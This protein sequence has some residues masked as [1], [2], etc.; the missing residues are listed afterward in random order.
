MA[1]GRAS[2]SAVSA[3]VQKTQRKLKYMI[4]RLR[5]I[6]ESAYQPNPVEILKFFEF[7]DLPRREM[8]RLRRTIRELRESLDLKKNASNAALNRKLKNAANASKPGLRK[9]YRDEM[10]G[11]QVTFTEGLKRIQSRMLRAMLMRA[12]M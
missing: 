7:L 3:P 12:P 2:K 8:T 6:H 11:H 5:K 4:G 10:R 1:S 9:S